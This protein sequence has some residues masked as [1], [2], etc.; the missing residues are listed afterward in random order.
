MSGALSFAGLIN[1]FSHAK[2]KKIIILL[3]IHS[4]VHVGRLFVLLSI[5]SAGSCR[6]HG[7]TTWYGKTRGG[8]YYVVGSCT[9]NS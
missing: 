3:I 5:L 7:I 6:L 1:E 9:K 2:A 8:N 4:A